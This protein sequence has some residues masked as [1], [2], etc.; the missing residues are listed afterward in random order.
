M[1]INRD[2]YR[3][4]H[5]YFLRCYRGYWL[6]LSRKN[7]MGAIRNFPANCFP[8]SVGLHCWAAMETPASRCFPMA[9]W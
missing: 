3:R 4:R 7:A 6:R 1:T 8:M 2:L 9:A 5:G